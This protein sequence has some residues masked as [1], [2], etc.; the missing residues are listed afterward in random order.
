MISLSQA[1]ESEAGVKIAKIDCTE[2]Q[3]ICQENVSAT[4]DWWTK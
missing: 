4:L 2:N 3:A 1:Y